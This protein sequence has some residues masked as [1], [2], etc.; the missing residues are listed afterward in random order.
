MSGR[1]REVTG[2]QAARVVISPTSFDQCEVK[3][4]IAQT[5][6]FCGTRMH[7]TIA[8]ISSRVPTATVSYSDKAQGVFESCAQ[9]EQVI[10]PR[11]LDTPEIVERL[12]SS[13]KFRADA[14]AS[15]A[16]HLPSVKAKAAEQMDAV[17]DGIRT[18]NAR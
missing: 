9:G 10:D 11:K 8:A 7:A 18:A 5:D 17:A 13:F 12:K 16:E 3:W 14:E 6:W 4:L 1:R 15:L 2:E